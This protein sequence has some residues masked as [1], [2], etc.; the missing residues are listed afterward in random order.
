MCGLWKS[1]VRRVKIRSMTAD[2]HKGIVVYWGTI[3]FA[4]SSFLCRRFSEGALFRKFPHAVQEEGVLG[5][6]GAGE[7]A[8]GD[9]DADFFLAD[10]DGGLYQLDEE[11]G[12]GD[13]PR[14]TSPAMGGIVRVCPVLPELSVR[15]GDVPV[16]RLLDRTGGVVV[17]QGGAVVGNKRFFPVFDEKFFDIHYNVLLKIF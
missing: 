8:G 4:R 1:A 7:G 11:Q 10:D 9:G 13:A 16:F 15:I 2:F 14:R 5:V 17:V 12:T 3:R 6:A